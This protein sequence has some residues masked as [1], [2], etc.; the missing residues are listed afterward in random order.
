MFVRSKIIRYN[1]LGVGCEVLS[2]DNRKESLDIIYNFLKKT[3]QEQLL[4]SE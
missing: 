3:N 2:E 1:L 4:F